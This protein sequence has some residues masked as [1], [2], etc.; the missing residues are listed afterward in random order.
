MRTNHRLRT[1]VSS[2]KTRKATVLL[3]KKLRKKMTNRKTLTERIQEE[4]LNVNSHIYKMILEGWK[5]E[6]FT[7]EHLKELSDGQLHQLL[8]T[9]RTSVRSYI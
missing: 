8:C 4:S 2:Y 3:S 9:V 7:D 6:S 5:L 1:Q